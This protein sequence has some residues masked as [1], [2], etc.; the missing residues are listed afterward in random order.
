MPLGPPCGLGPPRSLHLLPTQPLWADVGHTEPRL[1]SSEHPGLCGCPR[2]TG[3][4]GAQ[5]RTSGDWRDGRPACPG[6]EKTARSE[7]DRERQTHRSEA[8]RV[9]VLSGLTPFFTRRTP[10]RGEEGAPAHTSECWRGPGPQQPAPPTCTT[11]LCHNLPSRPHPTPHCAICLL[12]NPVI[13]MASDD[14]V[15]QGQ[16]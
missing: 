6:P 10:G 11:T 15:P 2:D 5:R 9:P 16:L 12:V 7:K 4:L 13:V 1:C 8:H 3:G 14:L